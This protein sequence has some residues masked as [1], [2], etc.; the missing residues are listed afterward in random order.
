MVFFH[1][2]VTSPFF[3]NVGNYISVLMSS[4]MDLGL[5]ESVPLARLNK[6]F[7]FYT[8]SLKGQHCHVLITEIKIKVGI[9]A[10][11]PNGGD[12][13]VFLTRGSTRHGNTRSWAYDS[14]P[15]D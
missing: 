11:D 5:L 4:R 6:K 10:K 2:T 14:L 8:V 3:V 12:G 15:Q 7:S 9:L 13:V 1:L